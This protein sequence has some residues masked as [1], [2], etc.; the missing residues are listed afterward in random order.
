MKSV[1]KVE[2]APCIFVY[3]NF[4][5]VQNFV[6]LVEEEA[7]KPWPYLDWRSSV[8]GDGNDITESEY[9]T[10]L[11]MVMDPLAQAEVNSD[12]K[13]LSEMFYSIFTDIDKCIWDYRNV[14]DL[15]LESSESFH[16]LKYNQGGQYHKHHDHSSSNNRVLSMVA[17]FGEAEQG[18]ELEFTNFDVKIKLEKNSLVLFPSNFP[19]SHI[20]HPIESGVKYSLVTWFV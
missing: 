13:E 2:K 14:N 15:Y 17:S 19:Y 4:F 10:S 20:A 16:L 3:K 7:Q 9:R 1:E 8:T 12:L 6:E 11:E 5:D 18:G